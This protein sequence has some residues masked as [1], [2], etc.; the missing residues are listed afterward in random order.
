MNCIRT[1]FNSIAEK[2]AEN[3]SSLNCNILLLLNQSSEADDC[4]NQDQAYA[5]EKGPV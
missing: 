4:K 1:S 2:A 5:N 3:I